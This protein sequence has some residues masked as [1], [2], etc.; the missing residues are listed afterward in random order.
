[1]ESETTIDNQSASVDGSI[2]T[3]T[4]SGSETDVATNQTDNEATDS[5]ESSEQ[6]ADYTDFVVPEGIVLESETLAEFKAMAKGIGLKQEQ[7]QG[8]T[9]LAI[10]LSQK[11]DEKQQSAKSEQIKIWDESARADKE[12]GGDKF[13]TNLAV[14]K[15]AL[16]NFATPELKE[17]LNTTGIGSNP[18]VIRMF[19]RIGKSISEDSAIPGTKSPSSIKT[20]AQVL[21]PNQ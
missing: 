13:D 4:E 10:K 9:D 1:M 16:D 7:A 3:T 2:L 21:Y 15:K 8:L 20:A 19:Y 12:L 11:W 6:A 17:L 18:D 14:A 5:S